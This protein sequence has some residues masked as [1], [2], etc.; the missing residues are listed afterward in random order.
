MS[1]LIRVIRGKQRLLVLTPC[2]PRQAAAALSKVRARQRRCALAFVYT[3]FRLI[4]SCM[5]W[6]KVVMV[7]ALAS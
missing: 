7:R 4:V 2:H 6:S 3:C 5:I 1:L